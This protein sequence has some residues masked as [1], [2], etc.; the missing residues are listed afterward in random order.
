MY[1]ITLPQDRRHN[2][3]CTD[4]HA[5]HG[6]PDQHPT[7]ARCDGD[8]PSL[9]TFRQVPATEDVYAHDEEEDAR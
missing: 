7:G 4:Q 1:N 5:P 6:R 8:F 2:A 3:Q 9:L